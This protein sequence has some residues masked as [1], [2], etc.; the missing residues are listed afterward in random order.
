MA[1]M[2]IKDYINR[3]LSSADR[4][5]ALR[6]VHYLEDNHLTFYKDNCDC[7]KDKIYYWVKL[8]DKC[9]CFIAVNDPDE[10]DNRWTVWSDDMGSEWLEKS[11][12]ADEIK[13]TAWKHVDH[14]GN[15]G[16]CGGGRRKVIFGKEFNDVC[17]C[18][19][20][21]DNPDL[22]DLLF[23]EKMTEIRI[24][25]IQG[26]RR[27]GRAEMISGPIKQRNIFIRELENLTNDRTVS[28][29]L[30][31][32]S[33]AC[34]CASENSDIDIIVLCDRHCFETHFT[35]GILVETSFVTYEYA[36]EKLN[37]EPMDVYHYLDAEIAF[38]R[39]GRLSEIMALAKQKYESYHTPQKVRDGLY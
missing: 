22:E 21:V 9:I 29:V 37:A 35:D 32:G 14:C 31:T 7:W 19:F 18:T 3:E 24:K 36:V 39:D 30:L 25:E 34:G 20:R 17:G 23:L 5:I 27:S 15:C 16:S 38:D 8:E 2:N 10:K 11:H 6:F 13:E 4:E 33:V 26:F 28:G 1:E 12:Y